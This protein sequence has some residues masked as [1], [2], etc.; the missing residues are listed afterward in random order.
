MDA[1]YTR[2]AY[3]FFRENAGGIVGHNAECAIALARAEAYARAHDWT[4]EWEY[5]DT[6]WECDCGERDC[7]PNEVLGCIL[8]DEHGN[9]LGSLWGI[10]DPDRHYRRV[11]EAELALEAYAP[12]REAAERI[13]AW[14]H[15]IAA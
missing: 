11:V 10:G 2:E 6:P 14:L 8:Q 9:P 5:D 1:T 13:E 3:D 4:Y 15:R 12:I 7:Q